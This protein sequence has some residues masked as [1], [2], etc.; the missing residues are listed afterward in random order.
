M[1]LNFGAA[2]PDANPEL[3]AL[4]AI[5]VDGIASMAVNKVKVDSSEWTTGEYR[6]GID[7]IQKR[8]YS[9]VKNSHEITIEKDLMEGGADD[10]KAFWDWHVGGSRDRRSGAVIQLDIEGN[11]VCRQTFKQAWVKKWEGP[12]Q[13]ASQE[14]ETPTY[15]FTIDATDLAFEVA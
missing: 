5:E 12:D 1:A 11:E 3:S 14:S 8:T 15:V 2:A 10:I 4:F 6:S 13:D 9:G 7:P